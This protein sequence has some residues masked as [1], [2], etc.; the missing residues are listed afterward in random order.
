MWP[1]PILYPPGPT[2]RA[3]YPEGDF[4]ALRLKFLLIDIP[5]EGVQ[6][7]QGCDAVL[8]D[9]ICPFFVDF[10]GLAPSPAFVYLLMF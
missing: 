3:S 1:S 2:L 6:F 10:L 5:I 8:G 4:V 7:L 9:Q